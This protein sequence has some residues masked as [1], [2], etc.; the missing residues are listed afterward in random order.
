MGAIIT[1]LR[2]IVIFLRAW[3]KLI[4]MLL[5]GFAI[6]GFIVFFV[7]KPM[8]SVSLNGEFIGYTEDKKDLQKKISEYINSGDSK[9]IAYVDI[10]K[11]PEYNLCLLKKG[12]T[13]NPEEVFKTVISS[14]VP[15]YKY[16]A[17]LDNGEEK[18]YVQSYEEADAVIQ[19]LKEKNSQNQASITYA[20]KYETEL[21]QFT[22]KDEIVTALYKQMPTVKKSKYTTAKKVDNSNTALGIALAEPV[23]GVITSRF[24]ARRSGTHTGLDI[25][26]SKGTPIKAAAAGT[27]IYT[28]YKGSYGNLV[29]IQHTDSIQTYYAHCS[30]ILVSNGA[31]VNQGDTISL[32]GSTGNST[33]P[34]LH[35]EI[36]VN[37]YAKNPQNYLYNR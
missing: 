24:G 23:S 35:L 22:G 25:A 31:Q 21:K 12:L 6:I 18:Y 34:H 2:N 1:V 4:T 9:T 8:Y 16:Y 20:L 15:Y 26:N 29:I 14:G 28:G 37:G 13:A 32:V 19:G 27:V 11:L 3:I 7:Y 30:K 36:R 10:E 17:I 5:I 33:G